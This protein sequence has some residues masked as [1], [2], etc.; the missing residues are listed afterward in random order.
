MFW[1][2]VVGVYVYWKEIIGGWNVMV[3]EID[4]CF[5]GCIVDK[6][7]LFVEVVLG[8]YMIFGRVDGK[9]VGS[10][11]IDVI[12]GK[13]YYV[14]QELKGVWLFV[15]DSMFMWMDDIEVQYEIKKMMLVVEQLVSVF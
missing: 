11:F 8:L 4:N 13:F 2:G 5:I 10:I 6:I 9:V 1:F 7:Y 3:V 12:F 14:K 15:F